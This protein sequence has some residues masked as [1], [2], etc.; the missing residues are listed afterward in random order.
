MGTTKVTDTYKYY[1]Y[2]V[3]IRDQ[4]SYI[5]LNDEKLQYPKGNS[6]TRDYSLYDFIKLD[7]RKEKH[8]SIILKNPIVTWKLPVSI[9]LLTAPQF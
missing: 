3:C 8:M 4:V 9:C 7:Y 5:H 1:L 2:W 6:H